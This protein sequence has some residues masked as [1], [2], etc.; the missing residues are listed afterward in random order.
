MQ[1]VELADAAETGFQHLDIELR[2]HRLD[3]VGRHFQGEAVHRLAPAPEGVGAGAARLGQPRHGALEG[4]AVQV[5]HRRHEDGMA[6]VA[7]QRR[8]AG[9]DG[10]DCAAGDG[11]ADVFRPAFGQQRRGGVE[12]GH[13]RIPHRFEWRICI[14]IIA[15]F[16]KGA[17]LNLPPRG[18]DVGGADRGGRCPAWLSGRR[19]RRSTLPPSGLPAISPTRGEITRVNGAAFPRGQARSCPGGHVLSRIRG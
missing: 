11:D 13:G 9:I 19:R 8:Y 12:C 4:V 2:R 1:V 5:R 3:V 6:L 18:G 7:G 17:G 14:D 15:A 16:A 10:D